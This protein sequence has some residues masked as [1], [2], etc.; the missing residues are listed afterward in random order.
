MV[1]PKGETS[2]DHNELFEALSD[3]EAQLKHVDIPVFSDGPEV[4]P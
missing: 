4:G 2:N 1:R 3:W